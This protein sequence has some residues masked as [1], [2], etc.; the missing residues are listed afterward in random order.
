MRNE[1]QIRLGSVDKVKQFL[2][3]CESF[4]EDIDV[5]SGR[6]VIDA[7]SAMALLSLDLTRP[8]TVT[9]QSTKEESIKKFNEELKDF[10][11]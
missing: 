4:R 8:I 3:I 10:K 6:Y 2:H 7:K 9:I 11:I 5:K 1:F